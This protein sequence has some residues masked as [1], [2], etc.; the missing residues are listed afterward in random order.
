MPYYALSK[1]T[2][3]RRLAQKLYSLWP[4]TLTTPYIQRLLTITH[5]PLYHTLFHPLAMSPHERIDSE[6]EHDARWVN[7]RV[8]GSLLGWQTTQSL[9]MVQSRV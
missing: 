1:D 5:F 7:D 3:I 6:H 2:H 4:M 9:G 8:G